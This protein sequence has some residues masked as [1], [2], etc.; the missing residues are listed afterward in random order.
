[1]KERK[2]LVFAPLPPHHAQGLRMQM[3]FNVL[4]V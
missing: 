2:M 1:M 4:R 3:L